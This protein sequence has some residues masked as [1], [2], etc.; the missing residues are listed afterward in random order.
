MPQEEL[1]HPFQSNRLR[2]VRGAESVA[3]Q[4][5][6]LYGSNTMRMPDNFFKVLTEDEEAA[7]RQWARQNYKATED[8][9][10][11]WHPVVRDECRLINREYNAPQK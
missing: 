8:V 10:S 1:K 2:P 11:V 7:Y 5:L 9:N 6:N 4:T 3:F